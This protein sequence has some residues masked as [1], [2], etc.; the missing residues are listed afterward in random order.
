MSVQSPH[1]AVRRAA[2]AVTADGGSKAAA[3]VQSPRPT[4]HADSKCSDRA[5]RWPAAAKA[6]WET[7]IHR[8]GV[9]VDYMSVHHLLRSCV[10]SLM[11]AS[12]R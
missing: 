3:Y 6:A 1:V 7:T 4:D 10:H 11:A 12:T 5:D 9:P 8:H 2:D